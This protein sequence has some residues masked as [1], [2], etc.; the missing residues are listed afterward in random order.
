MK[1]SVVH[2]KISKFLYKTHIYL[3]FKKSVLHLHI[4]L[5]YLTFFLK[6]K[7]EKIEGSKIHI[8]LANNARALHHASNCY[9]GHKSISLQDNG[10]LK[11]YM[12]GGRFKRELPILARTH[13]KRMIILNDRGCLEIKWDNNFINNSKMAYEW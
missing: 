4:L 3:L 6:N 2:I 12:N 13:K 11:S 10:Q 8:D 9:V 5:L 7:R 1:N